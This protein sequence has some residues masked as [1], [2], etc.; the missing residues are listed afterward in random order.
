MHSVF[1][2]RY[3][4]YSSHNLSNPG[5]LTAAFFIFSSIISLC[6]VLNML[7]QSP[8]IPFLA[9]G[10]LSGRLKSVRVTT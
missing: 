9:N 1:N 3:S 5:C 7:F 6:F 4:L 8:I 10:K 2:Y